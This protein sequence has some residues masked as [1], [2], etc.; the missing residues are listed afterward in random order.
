MKTI[1]TYAQPSHPDIIAEVRDFISQE[2][3]FLEA[4]E[5]VDS[6]CEQM[7]EHCLKFKHAHNP[8]MAAIIHYLRNV[9]RSDQDEYYKEYKDQ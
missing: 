2:M 4:A 9:V 8:A 3:Q 5:D 7:L 6:A 1:S